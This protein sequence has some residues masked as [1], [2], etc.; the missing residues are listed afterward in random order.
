ML[1]FATNKPEVAIAAAL[2]YWAYKCRSSA[3]QVNG[4]KTWERLTNIT[5]NAARPAED[6]DGYLEQL[7]RLMAGNSLRPAVWQSIVQSGDRQVVLRVTK[8]SEGRI[9]DIQEIESDRA[10]AFE[11]WNELVDHYAPQGLTQDDVIRTAERYP[12]VVAAMVRLRRDED[13]ALG[14]ADREA[15]D[16]IE[17][18]AIA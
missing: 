12:H 7:C 1:G 17:V 13:L 6:L 16:C 18:E 5:Q 9:G 11:S 15:D 3:T 8:D 10:L 4:I 2:V 14:Q